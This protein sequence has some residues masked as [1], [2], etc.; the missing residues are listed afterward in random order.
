MGF[1]VRNGKKRKGSK[2]REEQ[3][4][5]LL[6]STKKFLSVAEAIFNEFIKYVSDSDLKEYS[7]IAKK[8]YN[9]KEIKWDDA[10]ANISTMAKSDNVRRTLERRS[11]EFFNEKKDLYKKFV[12]AANLYMEETDVV[13]NAFM[14]SLTQENQKYL[15]PYCHCDGQS[16]NAFITETKGAT[17]NTDRIKKDKDKVRGYIE[18]HAKT[19][20]NPRKN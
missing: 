9:N 8:Y 3:Y 17:E 5:K 4:E 7:E 14:D 18:Y 16:L 20:F 12:D 19:Y 13:F 1:K 11:D 2:K 10:T 6:A 15:K